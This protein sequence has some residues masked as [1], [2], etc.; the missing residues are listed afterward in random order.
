MNSACF[1]VPLFERLP[2]DKLGEQ[3]PTAADK[4]ERV[5]VLVNFQKEDYEAYFACIYSELRVLRD[6]RERKI[7]ATDLQFLLS[8]VSASFAKQARE[9]ISSVNWP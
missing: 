4:L 8:L 1:D 3:Y 9:I 2:L 7:E 6:M 5:Q